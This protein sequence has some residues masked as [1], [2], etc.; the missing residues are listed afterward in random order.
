MF[1]LPQEIMLNPYS[2]RIDSIFEILKGIVDNDQLC[3]VVFFALELKNKNC[4]FSL[5][6]NFLPKDFECF[7]LFFNS[8]EKNLLE[9]SMVEISM[10]KWN[11]QMLDEYKQIMVIFR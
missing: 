4:K 1:S 8:E 7:P 11:D 2:E 9:N 5:Y 3:I 6:F 10:K